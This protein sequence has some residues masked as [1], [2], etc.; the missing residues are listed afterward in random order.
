MRSYVAILAYVE[1]AYDAQE[2][3][4]YQRDVRTGTSPASCS[5][6]APA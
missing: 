4:V 6:R 5:Q 3:V 2:G 1:A